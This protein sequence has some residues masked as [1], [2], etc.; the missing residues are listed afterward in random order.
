VTD[1]QQT[2]PLRHPD[3]PDLLVHMDA[4]ESAGWDKSF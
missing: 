4:G 3:F 1:G 2:F